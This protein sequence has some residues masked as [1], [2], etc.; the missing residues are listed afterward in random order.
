MVYAMALSRQMKTDACAHAAS[1]VLPYL[2][3]LYE[4]DITHSAAELGC[5]H[6]VLQPVYAE[7]ITRLRSLHFGLSTFFVTQ[8]ASQKLSIRLLPSIRAAIRAGKVPSEHMA[9]ALAA[10]LRF[11]TPVGEQPRMAEKPRPVFHGKLEPPSEAAPDSPSGVTAAEA[12]A[13]ATEA[14]AARQEEYAPGLSVDLHAGTYAF[15]DGDGRLPLLLRSLGVGPGVGLGGASAAA[16]AS[17]TARALATVEGFDV[18]VEPKLEELSVRV[19]ALLH[20]MLQGEAVLDVMRSLQHPSP[21]L[22]LPH[23]A[24]KRDHEE[25]GS[26][27]AVVVARKAARIR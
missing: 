14:E 3:Q 2:A 26:G 16:V 4:H 10:V 7:W 6:A 24:T 12:A 11:L 20:R 21:P 13:V 9:F 1:P 23:G 19:A 8:N 15:A 5:A 25:V 27:A 22:K 17:V 18:R